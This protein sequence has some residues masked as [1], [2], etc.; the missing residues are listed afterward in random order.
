M[1]TRI[2]FVFCFFIMTFS[3]IC[4]LITVA[5]P[6]NIDPSF[7]ATWDRV[8]KPVQDIPGIGRGYTWGPLVATAT[9]ITSEP[10]NGGTRK[11]Q[12]FDKARMEINN[13]GGN[14]SDLFYVTT[15]LLVKELVTGYVQLGDNSFQSLGPSDIQVAGDPN[16]SG[17]NEIAPTYS[18]FRNVVTFSPGQN[19]SPQTTGAVINAKIDRDGVVT[20][21][22]PPEQRQLTSYDPN[23][24]H[25]IAD[26]FVDY[27]KQTGL[28]SN[29]T[30]YVLG[31]VFFDNSTYVLGRPVTEPFWSRAVVSG[32]EQNVL[33]QLF[34]RRVLTYTPNNPA[35]FKVEM[36]NVGQHYYR[37]RYV[38]AVRAPATTPRPTA[39]PAMDD[40]T[41]FMS[42]YNESGPIPT[43]G[44]RNLFERKTGVYSNA[45]FALDPDNKLLVLGAQT[46]GVFGL[47]LND[48]GKRVW[49]FKPTDSVQYFDST[50]T[51]FNGVAY[52]G[53]TTGKVYAINTKDGSLKW[54]NSSINDSGRVSSAPIVSGN[55]VFFGSRNGHVYAVTADTGQL[56]WVSDDLGGPVTA[57]LIFGKRNTLYAATTPISKVKVDSPPGQVYCLNLKDGT[58]S[59]EWT[60]PILD[61][62]IVATPTY[63][64]NSIYVGTDTGWIYALKIDGQVRYSR[65]FVGESILTSPAL[66]D[67]RVYIG[68]EVDGTDMGNV[69]G[70]SADNVESNIKWQMQTTLGKVNSSIAVVD[71]YVYFGSDDHQVYQAS[72][73][74]THYI[75]PLLHNAP[76]AAP[77]DTNSPIVYQGKVYIQDTGQRIYVIQ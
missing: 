68:T 3:L 38:D 51:V 50:P 72:V 14:S 48:P 6:P 24:Q 19:T 69:Y 20:T 26:V 61:G 22:S 21:F 73:Y 11:V 9:A 54:V 39:L 49:T 5:A 36:G 55:Q 40:F 66:Y 44:R 52:I 57:G 13:P 16:D 30:G 70:L 25:N 45:S 46:D 27:G 41:Q 7:A 17:A 64:N 67:K 43:G 62:N 56:I 35:G 29:S 65:H 18:S 10:Y 28:I 15:G 74:D 42:L 58:K 31:S 76:A 4:P 23:T 8:D 60:V 47:D 77:F 32:V 75:M 53:T 12:Y 37:W 63:G 33:I 59:S 1:K 71:G 2:R 34:E